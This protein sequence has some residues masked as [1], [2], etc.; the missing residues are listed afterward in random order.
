V[1]PT[2]RIS[3]REIHTLPFLVPE[4]LDRDPWVLYHATSSA[5]CAEI[6]R[7][8]FIAR[9]DTAHPEAIRKLLTLYASIGWHG[10]S[11]GGYAVLSG[12]SFLRNHLSAER[13]IY[14]TTYAHRSPLYARPDF[15]GGETARGIRH[16]YRD[17]L[18]YLNE[19]ALREQHLQ[20]QRRECIALVQRDGLPSRVITPNLDWL[21][22]RLT[23]LAQVY[24]QLDALERTGGDGVIYAVQFAREDLP[25]M[26]YQWSNG[27]SVFRSIPAQRICH[28]VEISD[29]HEI[30]ATTSSDSPLRETWRDNVSEGLVAQLAAQG[31]MKHSEQELENA[32]HALQALIDTAGGVDESLELAERYGSPAVKAWAVQRRSL[33]PTK[34]SSAIEQ[35]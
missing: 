34:N 14:F 11:T 5:L 1:I 17:L 35:Q 12:F 9:E 32:H 20:K 27:V 33:T 31:G 29:S 28:K 10:I 23:A 6:E 7:E 18:R 4:T 21:R 16:A 13:P 3:A 22:T 8:G 25:Y 19:P 30:T 2:T 15:A 24:Q 26:D